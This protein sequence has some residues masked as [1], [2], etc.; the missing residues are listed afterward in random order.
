MKKITII[1]AIVFVFCAFFSLSLV[2][3]GGSGDSKPAAPAP[4]VTQPENQETVTAVAENKLGVWLWYIDEAG[5]VKGDH[6]S[7][8]KYL[9]DLGVKRVFIKIHDINYFYEDN[10]ITFTDAGVSCG[11]WQDACEPSNLQYYKNMGI[12][13]WAWTYNDIGNTAVQVDMLEA[14]IAIGYQ[15]FVMDIEVEFDHNPDA[16]ETIMKAHR[17]AL[18]DAVNAGDTDA[19]FLLGVTSWGNPKDHGMA[20]DI[21]DQYADF[22]MPQ[23]YVEKWGLTNQIKE[24]IALGDCEYQTLGATK[25]VWHIVSHEDKVLSVEQLNEFIRYAGPNASLWR[26]HTPE[27]ATDIEKMA[28]NQTEYVANECSHW[29]IE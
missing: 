15:G 3:C 16:L 7:M 25:P 13:P 8:A 22:H 24:T 14:A 28:W 19:S 11:V 2:G 5:L 18:N 12:E 17:D 1:P 29:A 20:I 26:I 4:V 21:I 10:A 23:T 6:Q 27:L 9:A